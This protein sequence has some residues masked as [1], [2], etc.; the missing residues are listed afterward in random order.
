LNGIS[1][2]EPEINKDE[3][4]PKPISS[5]LTA[6]GIM[7]CLLLAPLP[8]LALSPTQVFE[9]VKDSI[10]IVKSMDSKGA[11]KNQASGVL[12]AS[13]TVA[14]SCHVVEGGASF[15]AGRDKHLVSAVLYAED[16]DKDICLLTAG[17]VDGKPAESGNSKGLKAWNQVFAVGMPFGSSPSLSEGMIV[18]LWGE[19]PPLIQITAVISPD[20]SGGG[21][22][23]TEGRLIG[24]TTMYK[25]GEHTL[26]FAMPAEWIREV[27]TGGNP[28]KGRKGEVEWLK[29]A[30]I[31]ERMKDWEGLHIWG[32]EWSKALP[33]SADAP[34]FLGIAS[35]NRK[36][37]NEAVDA[38]RRSL[39]MVPENS[40]AWYNLGIT[41]SGLKRHDEAIESYRQALRIEPDFTDAWISLGVTYSLTG[42]PTAAMDAAR[43]LRRFDPFNADILMKMIT[44]RQ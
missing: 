43:E 7:S 35:R 24:L 33:S 4:M 26:N 20:M 2:K 9:K 28:A 42:N 5:K 36:S 3:S 27:R 13:G 18:K 39:E 16:G 30:V 10:V 11:V 25:D 12:I 37:Y 32:L 6:F 44:S 8:V 40:A 19:P 34:Y 23:D 31:L 22:F 1:R 21:L 38:F 14:T 17:E 41:Y 15:L 29:H